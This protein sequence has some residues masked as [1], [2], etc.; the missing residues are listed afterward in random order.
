MTPK[1]LIKHTIDLCHSVL[2]DYLSDLTDED[3]LVRPVPGANHIAWQLGHLI[4]SENA[5]TG[6]GYA[7]PELPEGFAESYTKE[8]AGSDDPA[9]FLGKSQ[10]LELF[11]QQRA[12][13]LA[14]LDAT[15]ES[16]LDKAAPESC[17]EYAPTV[18]IMFNLIGIHEMMH[19]AQFAI[20]RRKLGKP[21][22][23]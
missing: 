5:L 3:L 2:S 23:F 16:D 19:A 11:E 6:A 18:G 15:P 1:D 12:A 21:A 17:R 9:M 10:Y 14:A 13:T 8:T 22:L 20:V 4:A 7:M